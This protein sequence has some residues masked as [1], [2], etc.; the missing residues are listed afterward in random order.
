MLDANEPK[1]YA[2]L[3]KTEFLYWWCISAD[4]QIIQREMM[5]QLGKMRP[6]HYSYTPALYSFYNSSDTQNFI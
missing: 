3:L 5:Q 4:S 6:H 2:D 1:I